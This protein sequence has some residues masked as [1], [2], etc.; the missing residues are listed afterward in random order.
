MNTQR[1]AFLF[2][3]LAGG[4]LLGLRSLATGLPPSFLAEARADTPPPPDTAQFLILS[5]SGAGDP[6]NTT[7]PGSYGHEAAGAVYNPHPELAPTPIQLGSASSIAAAPWAALPPEIL[8]RT[9]FFHNSTYTLNHSDEAKVLR[10]MG[11]AKRLTNG[12]VNGEDMAV[13][14]YSKS[15]ATRL[16]TLQ[17]EPISVAQV[18]LSYDGRVLN[19][20]PPSALKQILGGQK[21]VLGDLR[22][23]RDQS[24]DQ[25]RD[26]LKD[27]SLPQRKFLDAYA[28]SQAQVRAIQE[29]LLARLDSIKSDDPDDQ[30]SAAITLILM[31]VSPVVTI[32]IPFGGD[33]HT[34]LGL[35]QEAAEVVS[36]VARVKGV[37]DGLGAAGLHDRATLALSNV[38]GRTF[39]DAKDGRTHNADHQVTVMI[40]KGVAGSVIGGI[41]D[42]GP[43][44]DFG[45]SA[46]DSSTG[47]AADK[48]DVTTTETLESTGKT[49][50]AALGVEVATLEARITGGKIIKAALAV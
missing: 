23:L 8:A 19:S 46:I 36:G 14:I 7:A 33:N 21:G 24:L 49:L 30:I 3:L 40:G 9:A 2:G 6:L 44:K 4:G 28:T 37:L 32:S 39:R 42:L 25:M 18:G 29:D 45:A 27:S 17:V 22:K 20:V 35:G 10:L 48:G 15:L 13:S 34:D 11:S 43:G 12:V 38:F 16:G 47:L 50:G 26:K 1:R 5:T 41:R 31:K